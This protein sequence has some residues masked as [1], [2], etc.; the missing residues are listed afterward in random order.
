MREFKVDK[1]SVIVADSNKEMGK[2]AADAIAAD[3]RKLGKEKAEIRVM[4]AAAPSQNTMFEALCNLP[5]IPWEKIVAFHMDEYIGITIDKPQSF[6]AF[7]KNAIFDKKPFKAVNLLEGDASDVEAAIKRYEG[8]LREM[9]M[10]MIVLGIGENGHIAFNDPDVA[11]FND[12]HL[13]KIVGLDDICRQ[14]QVNDGCFA[15][16]D[17]VP[18]HAITVTIPA[19]RQAGV[20]HCVVPNERKANAVKAALQGPVSEKCPASILRTHDN[21][22]LYIDA[23]S[24]SLL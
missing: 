6:R 7:L 10:D 9:P 18:S 11:D 17:D 3:L 23:G 4:F 15:T 12:K 2:I 21:A 13:V 1:L 16:F 14:Q 22:H 24:A 5:D 8:M 19:F 20:L